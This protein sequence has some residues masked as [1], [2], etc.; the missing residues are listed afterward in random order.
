MGRGSEVWCGV[1]GVEKREDLP[2]I[3]VFFTNESLNVTRNKGRTENLLQVNVVGSKPLPKKGAHFWHH[4]NNQHCP[5]NP[6]A[7][8]FR[9]PSRLP[10]SSQKLF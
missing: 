5:N 9:L 10:H 7:L 2:I 1:W 6:L 8:F 4:N 3:K